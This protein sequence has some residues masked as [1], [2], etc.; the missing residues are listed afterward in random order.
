MMHESYIHPVSCIA[1][2]ASCILNTA[3]FIH[4][5]LS[6]ELMMRSVS[7]GFAELS[8]RSVKPV[9]SL[10]PDLI[11]ERL[12]AKSTTLNFVVVVGFIVLISLL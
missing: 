10:V 11:G 7:I 2:P 9:L 8:D 12:T 6:S 4:V 1:H 5:H 3:Y